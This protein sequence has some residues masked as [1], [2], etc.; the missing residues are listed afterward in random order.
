MT[1][2]EN[3]ANIRF[4]KQIIKLTIDIQENNLIIFNNIIEK[5]DRK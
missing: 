5:Y 3:R 4:G 2:C 1:K